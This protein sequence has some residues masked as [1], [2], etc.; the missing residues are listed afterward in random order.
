MAATDASIARDAGIPSGAR[1]AA[2]RMALYAA[3][4]SIVAV[5]LLYRGTVAEMVRLWLI[6]SYQ[7]GWLVVPVC[8]WL[9]WDARRQLA[10]VRPAFDW[11]GI[12]LFVLIVLA[13]LAGELLSVQLLEHLA[14]VAAIPAILLTVMGWPWVRQIWFPLAL[15]FFAVPFGEPLLAPLMHITAAGT[16]WVL[17]LCGLTVYSDGF[18]FSTTVG[19]FRVAETCSGIRYIIAFLFTGAL[20]AY[21]TLHRAR[22]LV[23]FAIVTCIF[24]VIANV[25]RASAIVMLAHYSDM[26]LAVGIDHF[27][28]GWVFFCMM[29]AVLLAF[30][31]WLRRREVRAG[32]RPA[33]F[34]AAG[35][36][37]A[38]TAGGP[39]AKL[40]VTGAVACVALAALGAFTAGSVEASLARTAPGPQGLPAAQGGWSG[41]LEPALDWTPAFTGEPTLLRADYVHPR[42]GRVGVA[43]LHY[44]TES[45]GSELV[46]SGNG[47]AN[48]NRWDLVY[49]KDVALAGG[50]QANGMTLRRRQDGRA[51][52]V[53]WLYALRGAPENRDIAMKVNGTLARWRTGE[54]GVAIAVAVQRPRD[55]DLLP[56]AALAAFFDTNLAGLLACSRP[57]GEATAACSPWPSSRAPN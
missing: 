37:G 55:E 32:I 6:P 18:F 15:L 57:T 5:L 47:L 46:S 16:V 9:A 1:R 49:T 22:H 52:N 50:A 14:L 54:A 36:A 45:Q 27:I 12:V 42:F 7:H 39:S 26:K 17:R 13:W 31:E 10:A 43:V 48:M 40:G 24:P 30:G 51:V 38:G 23:I 33:R 8:L 41:P 34:E 19:D 4:A 44:A 35:I 3:L 11:R 53:W 29:L 25:L 20:Y 21:L 56:D 2:D 28:Y